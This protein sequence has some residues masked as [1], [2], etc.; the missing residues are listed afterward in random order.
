MRMGMMSYCIP[1]CGEET[2]DEDMMIFFGGLQGCD[3]EALLAPSASHPRC[4]LLLFINNNTNNNTNNNIIIIIISSSSSILMTSRNTGGFT[5]LLL[6][7]MRPY[8]FGGHLRG[9]NL[10]GEG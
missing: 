5:L 6:H 7:S 1:V 2:L 8:Y 3:P 9:P 10:R 4:F